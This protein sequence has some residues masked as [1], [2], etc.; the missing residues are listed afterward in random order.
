[1]DVVD[2]WQAAKLGDSARL[3]ELL[4]EGQPIDEEQ[5]GGTAMYWAQYYLREDAM[6]LLLDRGADP[7][8][9]ESVG[10]F[11]PLHASAFHEEDCV[12]SGPRRRRWP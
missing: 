5:N 9:R 10:K 2:F 3:Q 11:T 6:Q 8:R 1:M 7:N 4:D 12:G